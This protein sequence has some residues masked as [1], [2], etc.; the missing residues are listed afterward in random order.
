MGKITIR[1]MAFTHEK[2]STELTHGEITIGSMAFTQRKPFLTQ[3]LAQHQHKLNGIPSIRH[4]VT[5]RGK[6]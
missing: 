1:S 5:T 2:I 6:Q 4:S 3:A